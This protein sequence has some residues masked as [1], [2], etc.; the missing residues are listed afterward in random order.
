MLH[1]AMNILIHHCEANCRVS[2]AATAVRCIRLCAPGM[3]VNFYGVP[4]LRQGYGRA[5]SPLYVNP[6]NVLIQNN[7][8]TP[9]SDG[10]IRSAHKGNPDL[11]GRK[12]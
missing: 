5:G 7:R 12:T 9:P 2:A 1:F 3:G 6:V 4:R 11:R 8:K 10:A